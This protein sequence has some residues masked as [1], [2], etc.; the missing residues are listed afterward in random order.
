LY[1]TQ[2]AII[3]I[4]ESETLSQENL[5]EIEAIIDSETERSLK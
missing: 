4:C 5:E 1:P 2:E 3:E